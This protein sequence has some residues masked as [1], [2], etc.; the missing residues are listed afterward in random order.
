MVFLEGDRAGAG[1]RGLKI[2]GHFGPGA[3]GCGE[4]ARQLQDL[5]A[6]I[7]DAESRR[8]AAQ[9]QQAAQRDQLQAGL[10]AVYQAQSMLAGGDRMVEMTVETFW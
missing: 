9:Q 2:I 6:Q 7:A 10:N 1:S 4:I 8:Q 3:I 5:R